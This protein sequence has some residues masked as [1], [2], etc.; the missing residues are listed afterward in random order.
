MRFCTVGTSIS[1]NKEIANRES[2][3]YT[4]KARAFLRSAALL[5][6]HVR[7]SEPLTYTHRELCA[8]R[9]TNYLIGYS[10]R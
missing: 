2:S 3:I 8:Q 4:T 6:A 5:H 7:V 9:Q 1:K 10:D